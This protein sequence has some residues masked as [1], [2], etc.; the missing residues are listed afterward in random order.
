MSLIS[1][2]MP[3][4]NAQTYIRAA[5]KSI[6][7][8]SYENWELILINDGSSDNSLEYAL[9]EINHSK[10]QVLDLRNNQGVAHALNKGLQKASGEMILRM[11]ADDISHPLRIEKQLEFINRNSSVGILATNHRRINRFG[12]PFLSS[13]TGEM[14]DYLIKKTLPV[15]NPITHPSVLINRNLVGD[16]EYP[17][18]RAEDYA[19]WL[20][21][22]PHHIFHIMPEKLIDL[23]V[24]ATNVSRGFPTVM[25]ELNGFKT[26]NIIDL[27]E[28]HAGEFPSSYFESVERFVELGVHN[29][30][31]KAIKNKT[32]AH[33][34][35]KD[36]RSI[37]QKY[38]RSLIPPLKIKDSLF[39]LE[40][41]VYRGLSAL[42]P[43]IILSIGNFADLGHYVAAT[44]AVFLLQV[45]SDFSFRDFFTSLQGERYT[46][47][48]AKKSLYKYA[49]LSTLVLFCVLSFQTERNSSPTFLIFLSISPIIWVHNLKFYVEFI[50]NRDTQFYLK[51]RITSYLI[52]YCFSFLY[53][54]IFDSIVM[55]YITTV[56]VEALS[57][58]VLR[59][60]QRTNENFIVNAID[61][62]FEK[63]IPFLKL[64]LLSRSSTV[65]Q[66]LV[67]LGGQADKFLI[68]ILY[69][70]STVGNWVLLFVAS[71][72]IPEAIGSGVVLRLRNTLSGSKDIPKS[73]EKALFNSGVLAFLYIPVNVA[74]VSSMIPL[75]SKNYLFSL[76]IIPIL[77]LGV[78]F[79][80]IG[81]LYSTTLLFQNKYSEH[82]QIQI[83]SFVLNLFCVGI[84]YFGFTEYAIAYATKDF[85]IL[86]AKYR[87][88]NGSFRGVKRLFKPIILFIGLTVSLFLVLDGNSSK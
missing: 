5:I 79:Q 83:Q 4:Y 87:M 51:T 65:I 67:W 81:N 31:T 13:G 86:F 61:E 29:E 30:T 16:F 75:L 40:Q 64:V 18:V 85:V 10:T 68:A 46:V 88:A 22:S 33:Q 71:R 47:K 55:L 80:N 78:Y 73:W 69:N 43:L 37:S 35:I 11:D 50:R 53:Y 25:E 3:F 59:V 34:K 44:S 57:G 17:D 74:L 42:I 28:R 24:H 12:V 39:V 62:E 49:S 82:G 48:Q 72:A 70:P 7:K 45:L 14:N 66:T 77:T 26:K 52:G 76:S 58:L 60:K 38:H 20:T 84:L 54:Y 15:L 19:L 23:R 36:L 27:R 9:Q 2:V 6:N 56:L 41:L 63:E 8:Q 1:I 21:M 32:F